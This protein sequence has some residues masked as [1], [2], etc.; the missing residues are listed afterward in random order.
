MD[1]FKRNLIRIF[2]NLNE[3]MSLKFPTRYDTSLQVQFKTTANSYETLGVQYMLTDMYS[4]SL[5]PL[6]VRSYKSGRSN[7]VLHLDSHCTH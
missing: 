1:G 6:I 5:L 2:K 4:N 3:N 7:D